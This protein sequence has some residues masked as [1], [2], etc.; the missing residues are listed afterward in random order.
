MKNLI[1][2][3][4]ITEGRARGLRSREDWSRSDE[5][6]EMLKRFY[7][8]MKLRARDETI[9]VEGVEFDIGADADYVNLTAT[10]NPS[11]AEFAAAAD[12]LEKKITRWSV[13][14]DARDQVVAVGVRA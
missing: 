13:H 5:A 12:S 10:G 9:T 7:T 3:I 8:E 11:D 6:S 4:A 1:R 14:V 2:Q